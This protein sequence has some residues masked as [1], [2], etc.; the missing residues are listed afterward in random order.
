MTTNMNKKNVLPTGIYISGEFLRF[1]KIFDKFAI[2][3]YGETLR[4]NI[5]FSEF[6]PKNISNDEWVKILGKD[7]SNLFHLSVSLNITRNFLIH[8]SNPAIT[9]QKNTPKAALFTSQEQIDLLFTAVTHD[10]AEAVIGDI[11]LTSKKDT[12]E[13][14]EMIILRKLIH[15]ILGEEIEERKIDR[16]TNNV[17]K[18]LTDKNTKLGKAFNAIERIG[19][20]KTAI[21]AWHLSQGM[22][23]ELEKNLRHLAIR[24]FLIHTSQL[25]EYA[26]VYPPVYSFLIRNNKPI[27]DVFTNTE[28]QKPLSNPL[29]DVSEQVNILQNSWLNF[30]ADRN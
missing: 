6:K 18:I 2:T 29:A 17:H 5:R 10:W 25:I 13:N 22:N 20:V 14:K 11:P 24:V 4:S 27:S 15:E 12:D 28:Y 8:C 21:K 30:I 1:N 9:W 7:V 23:N 19:Y 26:K 16:I 3:K